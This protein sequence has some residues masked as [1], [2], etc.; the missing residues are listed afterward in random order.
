MTGRFAPGIASSIELDV[1]TPMSRTSPKATPGRLSLG[2]DRELNETSEGTE[3]LPFSWEELVPLLVHPLKVVCIEAI[4]WIGRPLSATDL[5]KV[6]E[7][8]YGLSVISYHLGS[9][10]K[11]G[12][13]S[14][15]R[16]RRVRGA[17]EK[18]YFLP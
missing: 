11:L 5:R 14:K 18:F 7:P 17:T 15:A 16:Q 3:I 9:L 4:C 1:T 10:A 13:L 6:F 2:P 8:E 12:I